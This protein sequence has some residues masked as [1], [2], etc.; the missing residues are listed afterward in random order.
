MMII[1]CFFL[2]N[3][4]Q[5]TVSGQTKADASILNNHLV[6]IAPENNTYFKIPKKVPDEEASLECEDQR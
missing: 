4:L 2:Q 1:A 3:Y 5:P 6:L